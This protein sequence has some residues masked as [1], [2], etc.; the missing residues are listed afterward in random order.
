M[1]KY[2]NAP[3]QLTETGFT[4]PHRE[5]MDAL[6]D[7]LFGQ[8]VAGIAKSRGKTEAE[9]RALVDGGPYDGARALDAGLVDELLYEDELLS[10]LKGAE[11]VTAGRYVKGSRGF[12]FDGR[13]KLALIYAVGDIVSG[14]SQ[15]GFGGEFVGSDTIARAIRQARKDDSVRAIVLRIDS[16][17]GSGTASDVMWREV[18]LAKKAKPVIM[19]MGDVAASG[20][21]YL[22][23]GGDA[24]VAEPG[25]ITGSIGVFGGKISLR[26]LYDKVGLS[27]EILTRGKNA[28]LFSSYRPW[29]DEERQ[30]F[31]K[32]MTSFYDEFVQKAA[33]GRGKTYDEIHAVAQGR[34]WTGAEALK[35]GL[36]DQLGGLEVAVSLAKERAKIGK[37]QEVALVVMPERKSFFESVLERQEDGAVTRLLPRDIRGSLAL[38]RVL[39]EGVPVARLPFELTFR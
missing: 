17:G 4:G 3:N 2:K 16:P 26:G 11:R 18:T 14:E 36:V 15:S 29:T 6:L 34:V 27:K 5:Q 25:T 21:Y 39:G 38:A 12:S 1:G 33:S 10:R 31:R 24:I 30:S 37:D 32:I 20:G 19:S 28:A 7:S 35:V 9:A 8:F 22:A 23:M 13:P